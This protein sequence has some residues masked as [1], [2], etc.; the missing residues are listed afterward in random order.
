MLGKWQVKIVRAF[1]KFMKRKLV[2][3]SLDCGSEK[4]GGE[5]IF[6]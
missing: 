4:G 6:E 5:R 1:W 3:G 2:P